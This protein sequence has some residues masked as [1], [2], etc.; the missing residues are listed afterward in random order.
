MTVKIFNLIL[1]II[2]ALLIGCLYLYFVEV[3][4]PACVIFW[5]LAPFYF[6]AGAAIME[7]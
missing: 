7:G 5:I 2:G 6:I 1:F 3:Y 4:R